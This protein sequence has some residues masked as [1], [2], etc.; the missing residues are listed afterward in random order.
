MDNFSLKLDYFYEFGIPIFQNKIKNSDVCNGVLLTFQIKIGLLA[1]TD[2]ARQIPPL[3]L[4]TSTHGVSS[5][6][7]HFL[8]QALSQC[9][10]HTIHAKEKFKA[11]SFHILLRWN[12]HQ[13][14]SKT[15]PLKNSLHLWKQCYK[16]SLLIRLILVFLHVFI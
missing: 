5:I 15:W 7:P 4:P 1:F 3:K 12:C 9:I 10:F 6:L 11:K 2:E 13:R 14:P 8:S 16:G